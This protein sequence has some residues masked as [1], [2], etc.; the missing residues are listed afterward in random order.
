MPTRRPIDTE[1]EHASQHLI[2]DDAHRPHIDLVVVAFASPPVCLQ[3]F[4]R[5]HEWRTLEGLG[6]TRLL[7]RQLSGISQISNFDAERLIT[8][9]VEGLELGLGGLIALGEVNQN[10][11]KL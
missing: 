5:H 8:I 10:V 3:L 4:W 1:H 11:V 7:G 2:E 6:S 9:Q